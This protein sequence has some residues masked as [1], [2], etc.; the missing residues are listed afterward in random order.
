MQLYFRP[1]GKK[2]VGLVLSRLE[3]FGPKVTAAESPISLNDLNPKHQSSSSEEKESFDE[4]F[5]L[6]FCLCLERHQS[7]KIKL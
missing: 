3:L 1:N 7:L 5:L 4:V 6:N 2:S